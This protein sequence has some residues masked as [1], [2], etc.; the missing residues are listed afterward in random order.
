VVVVGVVMRRLVVVVV[1]SDYGDAGVFLSSLETQP[2]ML[3]GTG[4][5]NAM[6]S[7]FPASCLSLFLETRMPY[8]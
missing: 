8:S 2:Y 5:V 3:V 4:R 1:A 6:V 7:E